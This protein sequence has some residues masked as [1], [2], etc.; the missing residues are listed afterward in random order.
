MLQ[1]IQI[2][3]TLLEKEKFNDA[4]AT[5]CHELCHCFGGDSS[6]TFSRALTEV[7]GLVVLKKEELSE[8]SRKW[9]NFFVNEKNER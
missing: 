4:F 2:K 9:Q 7:I 6:A 8:V 5:Y 1:E 3:R